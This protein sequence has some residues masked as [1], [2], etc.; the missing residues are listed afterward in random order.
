MNIRVF[1][2]RVYLCSNEYE[3]SIFMSIGQLFR[4]RPSTEVSDI[5][6]LLHKGVIYTVRESSVQM[7]MT[8]Y[9]WEMIY[10]MYKAQ[11]RVPMVHM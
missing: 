8:K 11:H 1:N 2:I 10:L 9:I 4:I 7:Y 5:L 6:D 3:Y